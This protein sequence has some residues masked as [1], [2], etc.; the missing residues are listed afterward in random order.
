VCSATRGIVSLKSRDVEIVQNAG[1]V[2]NMGGKENG[3]ERG[4]KRSIYMSAC[5]FYVERVLLVNENETAQ[6]SSCATSG[7]A[8]ALK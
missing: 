1:G 3:G 2:F 6:P 4:R 8:L 5:D 7:K